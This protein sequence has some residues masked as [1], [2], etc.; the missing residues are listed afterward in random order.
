MQGISIFQLMMIIIVAVI[1]A[2]ILY[3]KRK[4]GFYAI[5]CLVLCLLLPPIGWI[6]FGFMMLKKHKPKAEC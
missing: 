3:E 1:A 6:Y 2:S 4:V 5:L